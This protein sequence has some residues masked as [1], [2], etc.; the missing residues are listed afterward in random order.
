MAP[1]IRY[2][3]QLWS[4]RHV[5]ILPAAHLL[6]STGAGSDNVPC[7]DLKPKNWAPFHSQLTLGCLRHP[8][9]HSVKMP[10]HEPHKRRRTSIPLLFRSWL[11]SALLVGGVVC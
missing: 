2:A 10:E 4:N 3:A 8:A 7:L 5:H 9:Q 1:R 11:T 6:G